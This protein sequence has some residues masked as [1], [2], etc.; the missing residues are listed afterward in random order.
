MKDQRKGIGKQ[1]EEYAVAYL[2]EHG[3]QILHTNYTCRFG[4]LD[5]VVQKEKKII[6]VEVRTRISSSYGKPIDSI[7][8]L[9]TR[10]L[11]RTIRCYISQ[12]K[13]SDYIFSVD[14][15]TVIL[16]AKR[17]VKEIKWYENIM[18]PYRL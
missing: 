11:S 13:L 2:Q 12:Y 15:I 18:L 10:H 9:K 1:G 14:A 16:D 8:Y 6:F 3:Y 7:T 17:K 4:E 5:I